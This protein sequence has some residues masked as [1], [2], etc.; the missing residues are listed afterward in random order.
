LISS[1]VA[2]SYRL[3]RF[4]IPRCAPAPRNPTRRYLEAIAWADETASHLFPAVT[5]QA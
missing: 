3:L 2:L 1:D 5:S 4:I